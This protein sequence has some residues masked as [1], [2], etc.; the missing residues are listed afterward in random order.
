MKKYIAMLLALA[1]T[2]CLFAGCGAANA[3]VDT[4]DYSAMTIDELKPLL[5]TIT[6]GKLTMVTSP[7][8]APYE[9][10]A[11]DEDDNPTLAGFDIALANYIADYLGLELEIVTLDFNGTIT[12]LGAGKAD[13]GMA[14]YSPDPARE[15]AMSFSMIYYTSGQSF[16][17]STETMGLF[18][19]LAS[20]NNA[21]YQIGAQIGS[22]QAKL[23][24]EHTPDADIVE[25]GKVTNI[26]AEVV[27][28]KLDGA[29]VETVVAETY[30]KNYDNLE[31]LFDVPYDT[32]GTVVGVNKNNP[33]LLAAVN[34][35]LEAAIE[36]GSF[37]QYVVDAVELSTGEK[38]EG[39]LT[40]EGEI[41]TETTAE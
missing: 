13:I 36:D 14:G 27:G 16:V 33:V 21:D 9:F 32:A 15:N 7:D 23:A 29:F 19:D 1:L 37:A 28:G 30:A 35:A 10:Y 20:A 40:E 17:A 38:Y 6:E 34:L 39:L 24:K 8:F 31:V 2:L 3:D 11:L 41:P 12:E 26:I 22:I 18:T 5:T 4:T 25:L